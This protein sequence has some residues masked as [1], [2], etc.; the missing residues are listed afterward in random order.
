MC[1]TFLA[2][3]ISIVIVFDKYTYEVEP[4]CRRALNEKILSSLIGIAE[5]VLYVL[6]RPVK[7]QDADVLVVCLAIFFH[8]ERQH[9]IGRLCFCQGPDVGYPLELKKSVL[10]RHIGGQYEI[11]G[12]GN[13]LIVIAGV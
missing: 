10:A 5:I 9:V 3:L 13:A 6:G 7:R 8:T 12:K 11:P 4:V 1:S 2:L